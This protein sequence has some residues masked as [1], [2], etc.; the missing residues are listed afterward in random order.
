MLL[1][2]ALFCTAM[3]VAATSPAVAE[4]KVHRLALQVSDG[5]AD[6]MTAVLNV[7]GNVARLYADKG[8]EVEIRI[9]A[10]NAGLNML[11]TD[12]SP[13]LERLK[14]ISESMPN[15]TFEACN[16]T[17]LG[18]AKAEGKKPEEIPI[19]VRAAIVEAGVVSLIEL[20]EKGWVIVRP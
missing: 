19:F 5:T 7:A 3:L 18:M 8:E 16:N 11:R 2:R 12:K 13:V 17:R 1:K 20:A 6:K 10:F 4:E 14:S 9:V 15:V